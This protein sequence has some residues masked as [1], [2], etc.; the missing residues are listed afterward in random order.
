[1]KQFKLTRILLAL[2]APTLA[3]GLTTVAT[4]P[5]Q[6]Q[7]QSP[8]HSQGKMEKMDAKPQVVAAIFH[9]DW[10]GKCKQMGPGVMQTMENLKGDSSVKWVMFDLTNDKTKAASAKLAAANGLTK[11]WEANQSTGQVLLVKGAQRTKVLGTLVSTQSQPSM[12]NKVKK[13][14]MMVETGKA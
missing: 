7:A 9:A 8:A 10:C 13:A 1:M 5:A 12:E 2:A 14:V 3:I 6:S 11:V 4:A